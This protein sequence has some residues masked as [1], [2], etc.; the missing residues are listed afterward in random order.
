MIFL[1]GNFLILFFFFTVPMFRVIRW[2]ISKHSCPWKYKDV[3]D[4][5]D[6]FLL[7]LLQ[8]F[9]YISGGERERSFSESALVVRRWEC[10]WMRKANHALGEKEDS[11]PRLV[12]SGVTDLLFSSNAKQSDAS[13]MGCLC[14]NNLFE[15]HIW[16][17]YLQC[18]AAW[19]SLMSHDISSVF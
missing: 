9:S 1:G 4:F 14:I 18:W 13:V 2:F 11:S 8:L 15:S 5:P 16:Y 3:N 19:L 6:F 12:A 17:F 10:T 7:L